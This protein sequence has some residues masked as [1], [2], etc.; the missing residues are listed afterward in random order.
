MPLLL[1]PAPRRPRLTARPVPGGPLVS[2][3]SGRQVWWRPSALLPLRR[4]ILGPLAL[5]ATGALP[6]RLAYVV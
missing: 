3:E 1:R 4:S 5:A 6:F 2:E